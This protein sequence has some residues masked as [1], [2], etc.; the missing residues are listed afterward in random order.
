[1]RCFRTAMQEGTTQYEY[2][3]VEIPT[4]MLQAKTG[5]L[6]PMHDSPQT[7]RVARINAIRGLLH[8]RAAHD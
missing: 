1:M 5:R 8:P 4:L 7:A 6:R 2:E 3:L